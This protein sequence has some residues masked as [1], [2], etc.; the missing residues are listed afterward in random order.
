MY[1]PT[2]GTIRVSPPGRESKRLNGL[3]PNKVTEQ[4]LARTFQNIRLFQDMSVLENVMIGCHC[5]P[6]PGY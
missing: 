6:R 2:S 1:K 4:G 5:R 3:K